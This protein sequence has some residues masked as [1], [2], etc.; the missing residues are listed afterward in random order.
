MDVT[1]YQCECGAICYI[2]TYRSNYEIC[3][4]CNERG[5][6]TLL[7]LL[8][9]NVDLWGND[10]KARNA[11]RREQDAREWEDIQ[12]EIF[13]RRTPQEYIGWDV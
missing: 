10:A 2:A 1:I 7:N 9:S 12:D 5:R 4:N 11:Q 8:P 6:W 3:P 13:N